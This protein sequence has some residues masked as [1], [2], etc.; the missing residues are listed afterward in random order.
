M[1]KFEKRP[2]ISILWK[3]LAKIG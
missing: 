3:C 1:K 2:D